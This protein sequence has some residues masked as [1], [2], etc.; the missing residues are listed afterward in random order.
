MAEPSSCPKCAG[1]MERGF[2]VDRGYGSFAVA[3][4][5][6][7]EPVKSFISGLSLR[8]KKKL[9]VLTRRCRRC[10]FL[11]SYAADAG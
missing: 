7:G 11:E 10:G 5:V 8:G 4:W 6:E 2:I 3:E 9:K 1:T